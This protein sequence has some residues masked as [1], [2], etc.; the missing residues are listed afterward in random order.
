MTSR[1]SR[2]PLAAAGS[3]A[4]RRSSKNPF[5]SEV[6]AAAVP[7]RSRATGSRCA[8]S[9]NASRNI[10]GRRSPASATPRSLRL[11]AS[12]MRGR[13]RRSSSSTTVRASYEQRGIA[14]HVGE[15]VP[16][17]GAPAFALRARVHSRDRAAHKLRL[18]GEWYTPT[19]MRGWSH[20]VF[21]AGSRQHR[22][23]SS[24]STSCSG[25]STMG[26]WPA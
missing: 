8:R 24:P 9:L 20:V 6:N 1:R 4:S 15:S 3:R 21:R 18:D 23:T 13:R 26:A 12:V 2:T 11:I 7:T 19:G 14:M 16:G 5:I 25:I 17:A 22:A 10:S